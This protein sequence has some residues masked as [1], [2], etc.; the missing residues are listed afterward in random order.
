MRSPNIS[1]KRLHDIFILPQ[2]DIDPNNGQITDKQAPLLYIFD[3]IGTH[4]LGIK[5]VNGTVAIAREAQL[6]ICQ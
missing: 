6:P 1:I 4:F 3:R 5:M 2:R